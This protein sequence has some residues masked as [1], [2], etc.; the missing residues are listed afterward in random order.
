MQ[1]EYHAKEKKLHVCLV[2]LEKA[3]DRVS[4]KVLEWAMRKKEIPEVWVRSVMSL[5]DGAKTGVR[6]DSEL[7]EV[8]DWMHQGSVLSP[9]CLAVVVEIV[10]DLAREGVMSKLLYVDDIVLTSEII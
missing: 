6:V 5:C 8:K 2:D 3:F 7:S 4:R 10:T 9:F 1:E